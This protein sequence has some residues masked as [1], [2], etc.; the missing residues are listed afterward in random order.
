MRTDVGQLV[1]MGMQVAEMVPD[2]AGTWLFHCHVAQH[3]Q[4]GMQMVYTVMSAETMA[5]DG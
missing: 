4:G 2:N 5:D 1:A 3:L